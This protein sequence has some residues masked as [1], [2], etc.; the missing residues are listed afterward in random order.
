VKGLPNLFVTAVI[1]LGVV[2]DRVGM[3]ELIP[4]VV[5]VVM[6]LLRD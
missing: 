1:P 2:V 4:L 3:I 5:G 6:G